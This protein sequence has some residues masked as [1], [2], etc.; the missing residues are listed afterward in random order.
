VPWEVSVPLLSRRIPYDRKRLLE[1]ASQ[2]E[3]GW[4]WRKALAL[5]RQVLAAEPACIEV[6]ARAAPLLARSG[7]DFEAWE[8]YKAALAAEEAEG[9]E[10]SARALLVD[11]VRAL[12]HG[13]EAC[14]SLSRLERARGRAGEAMRLLYDGSQ[15][16]ARKRRWGEAIVL[17]R[18][19][20]EIEPWHPMTVL[21]L[22]RLL[23]R[24]RQPAEA[25]FLLDQLDE[26][27]EDETLCA[28]R[29]LSWRIEPSLRHSWRW[30]QAARDRR[31]TRAASGVGRASA[32][33]S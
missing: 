8:S 26:R 7:R 14:R 19:A 23:A 6:H 28:V 31:R 11:A 5:Y 10:G 25:L 3:G 12:P 2:L 16:L 21:A 32:S 22:A 30:L 27:V 18:E 33:R 13:V 29:G 20:R 15:R 17:L 1:R 4:R 24:D 9:D